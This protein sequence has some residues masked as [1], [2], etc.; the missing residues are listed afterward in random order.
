MTLSPV[1]LRGAPA[2]RSAVEFVRDQVGCMRKLHAR[3]GRFLA[4][5]PMWP[6]PMATQVMYLAV[7]PE[8]NQPVLGAPQLWRPANL[9]NPGPR[10]SAQRRL[11]ENLV[12][13]RGWQHTYY[14]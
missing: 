1:I 8:F 11:R 12:S 3:Y 4:I 14:R 13:M 6:L 10:N 5:E 9:T 7:G 2:L